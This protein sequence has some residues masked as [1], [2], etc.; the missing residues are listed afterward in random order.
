M[1]E[2]L[3]I[4][5]AG[6]AFIQ[7]VFFS[8]FLLVKRTENPVPNRILAAFLFAKAMC[9]SNMLLFQIGR[10]ALDSC[11]HGFLVGAPFTFL[12]GPLL[13][14]YAKSLTRPDFRLKP[15]D[16]LHGIPFAF[17]AA[18]W[19]V[20]FYRFDAPS[21]RAI[22]LSGDLMTF[23]ESQ[24]QG[25][26]LQGLI[27]VYTVLAFLELVRYRS[28]IRNSLSSIERHNLSWLTVVLC[29]FLTKWLFDVSY[30]LVLW[31]LHRSSVGLLIGVMGTLLVF[32]QVLVVKSMRQ[33]GIVFGIE[34]KPKY[35]GSTLTEAQKREYVAR[36]EAVMAEQK[37]YLDPLLTLPALARE[38]GVPPRGLSQVLNENLRCN[39]FDY[40]NRHRIEESKRLLPEKVGRGATVFEVLLDAGFTS[41]STFNSAF[42]RHTGMTPT[43]FLRSV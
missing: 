23:R 41:K 35:S 11:I 42:K 20:R 9:V 17:M 7:L 34:D 39:F 37:P 31:I 22:L 25:T 4:L 13:Y 16:A 26:V 27:L 43:T 12:W 5:I 33:P 3:L 2:S 6:A 28:A 15:R 38:A 29:G 36:L 24:I 19:T 14:L 8:C 1:P 21:K 10:P 32:V 18:L 30:Y 40:V